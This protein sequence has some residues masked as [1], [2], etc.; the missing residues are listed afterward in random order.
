MPPKQKP[1][2]ISHGHFHWLIPWVR[3]IAIY[4]DWW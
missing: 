2:L 1:H 3:K 4:P